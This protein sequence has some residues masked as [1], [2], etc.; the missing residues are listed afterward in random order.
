MNI[1]VRAQVK[2]VWRH[3]HSQV[4]NPV[5]AIPVALDQDFVLQPLDRTVVRGTVFTQRTKSH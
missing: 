4:G 1:K 3:N 2:L 5:L